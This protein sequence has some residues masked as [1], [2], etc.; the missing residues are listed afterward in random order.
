MKNNN[1]L[2]IVGGGLAGVEAAWMARKCG[3]SVTLFEMKPVK[4][5][6]AHKL[7][8]LAELVCSNSLK[9]T[10]IENASGLL[11][12]EMRLMGSL[13]IEAAEATRLPAGGALAVDREGF[14]AYITEKLEGV[15]VEI[16]RQEILTIPEARPL[17]IASG[18]LTSEPLAEAIKELVGS[19]SLSFYDAISPVVS[20]ESI[21]FDI[22]FMGSRYDK[23]GK[24]YIN[25]PMNEAEYKGFVEALISAD[26]A[27]ARDFEDIPLFEGCMPVEAMAARGIDTLAFGPLRPV[28]FKDPRTGNRPYAI[29]QLRRD[30]TADTLYNMVGFQTR[31]TQGEQRRVFSM[32]PAMKNLEFARFGS[33]HRNSYIDSPRLLTDGLELKAHAGVFFAGQITGVEGYVE[34]AASGIFAG[35]NAANTLKGLP[36][37]SPPEGTMMGAL[38]AYITDTERKG[39]QPMN[40]NFGLLGAT[41]KTRLKF[42]E[43]AISQVEGFNIKPLKS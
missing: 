28:G 8:G 4:F 43:R 19:E 32:I 9:S 35:L 20:K 3:V 41:K 40:A 21:D 25:C 12:E 11:K 15:G 36:T 16:L 6:P 34:S 1:D 39:F 5:S 22:A 38:T 24:D 37:V 30:N 17:I 27:A 18:P 31:L 7:E 23:G 26:K 14:S 2:T 10:S 13:I 33:I 29:V 42:I